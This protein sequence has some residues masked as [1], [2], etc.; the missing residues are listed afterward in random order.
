MNNQ[1]IVKCFEALRSERKGSVEQI[2]DLIEKFVL[3][4]R[5][6][7]YTSLSDEGEVDW[8]RRAIYD[9]T[10]IFACQSLAASIHGNLTSP[11]QKWF[12]LQFR[13]E[14]LN[15]DDA[16]KEWLDDSTNKLYNALHESNFDIEIAEAY[17]DIVGF[18]TSCLTEEL[19]EDTGKLSF[20]A[21]PVREIYFEEDHT[22]Q[23][24]KLYRHLQ[25]TPTQIISKFG[26]DKVPESVKKKADNP[27]FSATKLDIIFCVFPRK[28]PIDLDTGK[29]I[30][31][32]KRPFGYKYLLKTGAELLGEEGG[33]YEMPA[34]VS[35][36]RKT[37][38]SKWG[39][40]PATVALADILTLNQVKEATLEAAGKAIDPANLAEEAALLGDINLDRG[41]LTIVTDIN[42]IKP[43]ESGS[44]FDVSNLEIQ[45]LVD[46]IRKYFYQDQLELKESPAMTATEVNVRYEL[47]QRL[48][49]PTFGRLK[50]D[51]LDPLI[52]R[53]FNIMYRSGQLLDLPE[54][55]DDSSLDIEY[56]GPLPRSQKFDTA[57][58]IQQFL[59]TTAQLAE[60]YPAAMDIVDI[61]GAVRQMALMQGVPA[62]ALKGQAQIDEEREEKAKKQQAAE[63]I[64][65][66][67]GAGDAMQSVGAAANE[68][69]DAGIEIPEGA[70]EGMQ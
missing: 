13:D 49:G 25:W 30:A 32:K 38:G 5:G 18:G 14:K 27:A 53:A 33:Y 17:L 47:M 39:H 20:T 50:T 54:G 43:Y 2:W 57:Q 6:D 65:A 34:F 46:A 56:S 22:K 68:M 9:A 11:A 52:K 63:Q 21:I 55:V 40:S 58:A 35:R 8:H 69:Q 41:A 42:G 67:Q 36:W 51:L 3:P 12:A 61:D 1:D 15:E 26:E 45:M 64:A 19:D 70:M 31:A 10:A 60:A 23:V 44:R 59:M 62:K 7:F 66:L 28:V 29:P 24:S 48:L 4:L 16:V 37:A